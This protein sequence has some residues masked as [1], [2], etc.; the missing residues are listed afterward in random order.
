MLRLRWELRD[1]AEEWT[2]P[3][4]EGVGVVERER[5]EGGLAEVVL[6]ELVGS[7][8]RVGRSVGVDDAGLDSLAVSVW[9]VC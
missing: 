1:E 8:E 3:S 6:A 5:G 4:R 7:L 9:T 2:L